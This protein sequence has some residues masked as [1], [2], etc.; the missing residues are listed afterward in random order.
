MVAYRTAFENFDNFGFG[1]RYIEIL[2]FGL[3]GWEKSSDI[4]ILRTP[5][6][7]VFWCLLFAFCFKS[8]FLVIFQTFI[9]LYQ[10]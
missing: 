7:Y 8:L 2:F 1:E 6:F 3:F 5:P 4:A 9:I 10:N